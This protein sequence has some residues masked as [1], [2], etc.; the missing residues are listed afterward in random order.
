MAQQPLTWAGRTQVG[1]DVGVNAT[2]LLKGVGKDGDGSIEL[3]T[4]KDHNL[5]PGKLPRCDLDHVSHAGF[6]G[7]AAVPA[8][9]DP[10][11]MLRPLVVRDYQAILARPRLDPEAP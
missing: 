8:E 10:C 5:D 6:V 7:S 2:G 4:L 1:E 9:V 3:L 11:Q